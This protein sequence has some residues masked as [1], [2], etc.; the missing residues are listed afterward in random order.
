[1]Y[2]FRNTDITQREARIRLIDCFVNAV[3]VY[4]N[5]KIVVT[6]NYKDSAETVKLG[7]IEETFGSTMDMGAPSHYE[8]LEDLMLQGFFQFSQLSNKIF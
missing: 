3:Y 4:D 5:D 8:S 2:K 6:L 1:M 7:E